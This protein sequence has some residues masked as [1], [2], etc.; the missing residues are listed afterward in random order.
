MTEEMEQKLVAR[1][2]SALAEARYWKEEV[3][4]LERHNKKHRNKIE[5]LRDCIRECNGDRSI[6][7]GVI[8]GELRSYGYI[9]GLHYEHRKED[10]EEGS[11][12]AVFEHDDGVT[13][14]EIPDM[15][16]FWLLHE[17]FYQMADDLKQNGHWAGETLWIKKK[18][19]GEWQ[20]DIL[21]ED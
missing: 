4:D 2:N 3:E 13:I 1:L 12:R 10:E 14:W 17:H 9:R 8:G 19:N 20:L 21:E 11:L 15:E 6:F 18:T 16:L 7:R 5:E